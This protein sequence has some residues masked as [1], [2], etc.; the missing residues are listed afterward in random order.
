MLFWGGAGSG[1]ASP[2]NTSEY[3]I[4]IYCLSAGFVEG[5]EINKIVKGGGRVELTAL[6]LFDVQLLS[7]L[8]L[9]LFCVCVVST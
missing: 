2:E 9:F 7:C 6:F 4:Y 1:G 3:F 5:F 8:S